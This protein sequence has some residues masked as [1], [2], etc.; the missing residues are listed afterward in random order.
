MQAIIL[1]R[2][3][4]READQIIAL[5]TK[6]KGKIEV[7]ARGVKKITSK[8]SAH[9]E[10]F[11]LVD[12]EIIPGKELNHLGTVQPI[13][14]FINIRNDLQKSLAAGYIVDL[15]AKITHEGEKDENIFSLTLGWLEF[16][17]SFQLTAFSLQLVDGYIVK[18]LNCLG[19]GIVEVD[20][21]SLEIKKGLEVFKTGEWKTVLEYRIQNIEYQKLHKYIYE[22]IISQLERKVGDWQKVLTKF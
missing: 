22:F 12:V 10:P 2:R 21:L 13:N 6:E 15:L 11:S 16:V 14:Y 3:D 1:S 18:L 20:N 5:Y 8:N 17:N 9:L 19:F 7:L 4:F